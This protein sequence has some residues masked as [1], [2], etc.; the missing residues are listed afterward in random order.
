[1]FL[2]R[3]EGIIYLKKHQDNNKN[4]FFLMTL[5]FWLVYFSAHPSTFLR[6]GRQRW[7]YPVMRD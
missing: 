4:Y 7:L 6:R 3:I 1:M 5:I 2:I